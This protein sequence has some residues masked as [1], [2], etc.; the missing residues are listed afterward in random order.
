MF[1]HNR[2]GF[3]LFYLGEDSQQKETITNLG[4]QVSGMLERVM[5]NSRF[6]MGE[7]LHF[8]EMQ[9]QKKVFILQK[10]P[11]QDAYLTIV[12][13]QNVNSGYIRL[14]IKKNLDDLS[15]LL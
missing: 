3:P 12:G 8:W 11:N 7:E 2:V 14:E 6:L 15:K 13:N 5:K 1:V 4:N 10:I 9:F